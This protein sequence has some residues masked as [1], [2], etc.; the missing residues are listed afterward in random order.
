V[1]SLTA[2]RSSSAAYKLPPS[3]RWPVKGLAGY[4]H[5][6]TTLSPFPFFLYYMIAIILGFTEA[7]TSSDFEVLYAGRSAADA[8]VIADNPPPGFLRTE[9]LTNPTTNHRRYFPGNALSEVEQEVVVADLDADD[10]EDDGEDK[11]ELDL[12]AAKA[13]K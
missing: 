11:T 4:Y 12:P 8:R 10:D 3:A 6:Q 9:T 1:H 2:P 7:G 13:K 5:F